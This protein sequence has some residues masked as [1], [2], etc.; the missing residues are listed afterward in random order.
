[1]NGVRGEVALSIGG[2]SETLCLTLGALAE[3]ETAFRCRSLGEL[4]VRLKRL[5]APE[6]IILLKILV[7]KPDLDVSAVS[8]GEAASAIAKAFHAALG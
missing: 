8:P 5:S 7:G 6:I 1:M 2:V 4:Q 3:I